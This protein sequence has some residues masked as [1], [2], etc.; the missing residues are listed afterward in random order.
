MAYYVAALPMI[1]Y[2]T[3]YTANQLLNA[4][5]EY[6]CDKADLVDDSEPV[7]S[8][9]KQVVKLYKDMPESH[10]AYDAK[11][12]I[13]D[14]IEMLEYESTCAQKKFAKW[15][16]V[17]KDFKQ[18]NKRIDRLTQNLEQRMRL[19]HQIVNLPGLPTLEKNHTLGPPNPS[20]L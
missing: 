6:F 18:L 4:T 1:Y 10:H 7:L 3:S 9:A 11:A 17:R 19:F 8:A 13:E 12:F 14:G 15:R 5:K 16:F 20:P 2:G